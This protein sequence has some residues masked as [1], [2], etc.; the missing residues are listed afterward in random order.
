MR[1]W[2][3]S[4]SVAREENPKMTQKPNAQ[5]SRLAEPGFSGPSYGY[6][7]Q[8]LGV[9]MRVL[10]SG[11]PALPDLAR[12]PNACHDLRQAGRLAR[13]TP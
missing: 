2:Q 10:T 4:I 1:K 5:I 9:G 13:R 8:S 11:E 3:T 7:R 12:I 6:I